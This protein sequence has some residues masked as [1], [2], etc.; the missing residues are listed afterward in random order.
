MYTKGY[1]TVID[2]LLKVVREIYFHPTTTKSNLARDNA[3]VIAMA[4]CEGL[5]TTKV[6]PGIY[7]SEWRVTAKGLHLLNESELNDG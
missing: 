5:I 6:S 3:S 1:N 4:A 2:T 7:S